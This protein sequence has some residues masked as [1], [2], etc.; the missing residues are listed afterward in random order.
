MPHDIRQYI[1]TIPDFPQPGI[2]FRDI[3][4]LFSHAT[5]LN[6]TIKQ[7]IATLPDIKLD[8]VAG[9]EAR[10]FIIGGAIAN[11]LGLGFV[12]IRKAGKLPAKT[13]KQDYQLEYGAA[14]LE[15]HDD[16]I[17]AG[18]NIL[19]VDD[20][21]ATGGTAEAGIKLI[22]KLGGSVAQASFIIDLPD[23][24]GAEKISAMGVPVNVLCDFNG[25]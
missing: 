5:G 24:G 10:G 25:H 1:R 12:P 20:L 6:E 21:I 4:T 17:N 16:A 8:K 18:E 11:E 19:L 23:L 13:I 15:L 2:M 22:E 7:M 9:L 14:T 3:T